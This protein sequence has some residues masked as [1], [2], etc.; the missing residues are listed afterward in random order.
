MRRPS[1]KQ[2]PWSGCA[3]PDSLAEKAM[4][5]MRR[6]YDFLDYTRETERMAPS[7]LDVCPGQDVSLRGKLVRLVVNIHDAI[8]G[9]LKIRP[10]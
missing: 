2:R 10:I 3:S 7:S 8:G 1:S 4:V 9:I 6:I 5:A